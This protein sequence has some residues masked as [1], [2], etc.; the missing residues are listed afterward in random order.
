MRLLRYAVLHLLRDKKNTVITMGAYAVI[1]VLLMSLQQ[2]MASR[3]AAMD[4]LVA[5]MTVQCVITDPAGRQADDL[6]MSETY[7]YAFVEECPYTPYIRNVC[8]RSANGYEVNGGTGMLIGMTSEQ[9]DHST[10]YN[11]VVYDEGWDGTLWHS[12][13]AVCVITADLMELTRLDSTGMRWMDVQGLFDRLPN[14]GRFKQEKNVSVPLTLRVAGMA[15]G[16]KTIYCPFNYLRHTRDTG[17]PDLLLYADAVSF[18]VRDNSR[19]DEFRTLIGEVYAQID[20]NQPD[21]HRQFGVL[22]R[23]A[24]FLQATREAARSLQIMQLIQPV[25]YTCAMGAGV[26]LAVIQ[27]RGRK[28]ELAVLRS[29]G[30]GSISAAVSC[31]LENTLLCLPLTLTAFIIWPGSRAVTGLAVWGAFMLGAAGAILFFSGTP[32]IR[33]IRELEE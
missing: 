5:S 23:D 18:E 3:R 2:T 31:L 29:L 26:M 17:Y 19:I 9:A 30:T 11:G 4:D 21:S 13:E 24:H 20:E 1:F 22:F 27:M 6:Q 16:E 32:L 10:K 14:S 33:Q 28:K 12:N 8:L 15:L 7:Y 25:L